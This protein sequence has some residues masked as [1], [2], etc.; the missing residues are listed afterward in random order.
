MLKS[1]RSECL[2]IYRLSINGSEQPERNPSTMIM[3]PLTRVIQAVIITTMQRKNPC[4][5]VRYIVTEETLIDSIIVGMINNS[6]IL[7]RQ[8][9]RSS[10][11]LLLLD[12]NNNYSTSFFQEYDADHSEDYVPPVKTKKVDKKDGVVVKKTQGV[13]KV[14]AQP[15][16]KNNALEK[17]KK[18]QDSKGIVYTIKYMYI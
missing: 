16:P 4:R 15:K 8:N 11:F 12:F 9:D 2:Y 10:Y 13:K 14:K 5:L 1:T 17:L 18:K 6:C 7:Y 3:Q